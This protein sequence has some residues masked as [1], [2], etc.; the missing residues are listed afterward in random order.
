[1]LNE[2]VGEKMT[3][4]AHVDTRCLL[5]AEVSAMSG[6]LAGSCCIAAEPHANSRAV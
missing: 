2:K 5:K 4:V 6:A 1:M 3:P